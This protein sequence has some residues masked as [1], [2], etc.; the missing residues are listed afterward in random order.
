MTMR[1]RDSAR[2]IEAADLA[3]KGHHRRAAG[4]YQDMGNEVRPKSQ[5]DSLW[6]TASEL[7]RKG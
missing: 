1:D 2:L 6:K 7:R 3:R 4:I 5:K